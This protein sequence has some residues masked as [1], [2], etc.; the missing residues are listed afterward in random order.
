[1]F[2]Q[3]AGC[4]I[5]HIKVIFFTLDN[6][7]PSGLLWEFFNCKAQHIGNEHEEIFCMSPKVISVSKAEA[8]CF[9]GTCSLL[10]NWQ[11]ICCFPRGNGF[12]HF[13][14]YQKKA[15]L[16]RLCWPHIEFILQL[17]WITMENKCIFK[18]NCLNWMYNTPETSFSVQFISIQFSFIYIAPN[19]NNCHLKAL[20]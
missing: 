5:I 8:V 11:M 12:L 10:K 4:P 18:C 2:W 3:W 20:K 7:I 6:L 15:K 17:R 1:M 9:K 13:L 19:Y 14:V 16:A